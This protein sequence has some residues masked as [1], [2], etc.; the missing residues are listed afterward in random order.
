MSSTS[1]DERPEIWAT[2]EDNPFNPFTQWNRWMTYDTTRGYYTCDKISW[3]A[4]C[5]DN[6][7][8]EENRRNLDH[9]VI[10]LCNT[11]FVVA[12]DHS[13]TFAYR[14]VSPSTCVDW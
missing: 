14:I 10:D 12:P 2:T 11:A 3:L 7:T 13:R 8:D 5:S 1:F 6:L 9:A 4:A